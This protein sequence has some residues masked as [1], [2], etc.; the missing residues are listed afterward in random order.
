M[1]YQID[2]DTIMAIAEDEVSREAVQAVTADGVSLYD[3]I[4]MISRDEDKKKRMMSEVLAAIKMQCNRFV[5]H[6]DIVEP[7]GEPTSFYFELDLSSRRE[8]G[9]EASLA[10]LFRS[11]TV[12]LILNKYFASKNLAELAAKYDGQ[13]LTDVQSLAKLLYEKLPPVYPTIETE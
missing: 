7:E 13:A 8:T 1:E 10:T 3:G 6:A 2:Y 5:L 11:L 4:R 9:K 12:N